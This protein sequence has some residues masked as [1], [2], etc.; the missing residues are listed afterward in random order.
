MYCC[1]LAPSFLNSNT[2]VGGSMVFKPVEIL[3]SH[4][5]QR[6]L[7]KHCVALMT[8]SSNAP[9][10]C[11]LTPN[12]RSPLPIPRGSAA[13][14][15]LGEVPMKSTP[16]RHRIAITAAFSPCFV[17]SSDDRVVRAL[18]ANLGAKL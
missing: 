8:L 13:I 1:T 17:V 16:H 14:S 5:S 15:V 18:A 12:A 6:L 10:M 11:M 7:C 3:H 9:E 2:A 4:H